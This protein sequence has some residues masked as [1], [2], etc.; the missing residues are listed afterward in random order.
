MAGNSTGKLEVTE[1]MEG[2]SSLIVF[3]MSGNQGSSWQNGTLRLSMTLG[4]KFRVSDA[5]CIVLC[6]CLCVYIYI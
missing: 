3:S 6:V 5:L 4:K 2:M 1:E